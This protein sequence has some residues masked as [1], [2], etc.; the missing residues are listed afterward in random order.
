MTRTRHAREW[1]PTRGYHWRWCN[2]SLALPH[3]KPGT[4]VRLPKSTESSPDLGASSDD[5]GAPRTNSLETRLHRH[6]RPHPVHQRTLE[7]ELDRV[8]AQLQLSAVL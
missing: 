5:S 6:S 4:E 3:R 7:A 2:R 8:I 1:R